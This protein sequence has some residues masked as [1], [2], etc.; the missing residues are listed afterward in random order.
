MGGW[1]LLHTSVHINLV[2]HMLTHGCS[3]DEYFEHNITS[4]T[5]IKCISI[6]N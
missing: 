4:F 6:S 2:I 1:G 3:L 5:M